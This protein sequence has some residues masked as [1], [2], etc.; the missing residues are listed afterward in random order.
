[1]INWRHLFSKSVLQRCLN[2]YYDGSVENFNID[3][4]GAHLITD[5][6]KEELMNLL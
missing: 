4:A 6:S 1:M 5:M 2:Y 3:G